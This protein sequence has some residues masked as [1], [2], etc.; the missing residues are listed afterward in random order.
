[1]TE[2]PTT[3]NERKGTLRPQYTRLQN[4][5]VVFWLEA[6]SVFPPMASQCLCQSKLNVN[7]TLIWIFPTGGNIYT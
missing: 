5:A 4:E 7:D 2:P 1:M 6:F 3:E